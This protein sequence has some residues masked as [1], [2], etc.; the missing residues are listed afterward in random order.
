MRFPLIPDG[1]CTRLLPVVAEC[2][3]A[4]TLAVETTLSF[5]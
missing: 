1:A 3:P 2:E 5:G 4:M